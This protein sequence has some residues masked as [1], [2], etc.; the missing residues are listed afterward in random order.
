MYDSPRTKLI[1]SVFDND[2]NF[3]V[4]K[5][6]CAEYESKYN[7]AKIYDRE[8]RDHYNNL[9]KEFR[10]LFKQTTKSFDINFD[11]AT[12][13]SKVTTIFEEGI[14]AFGVA[15]SENRLSPNKVNPV[16]V[17][18]EISRT[19]V[20]KIEAVISNKSASSMS[21]DSVKDFELTDS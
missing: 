7:I 2:T 14:K 15:F 3:D 8:L 9:K 17:S 21:S 13:I 4:F 20:D 19:Y 1:K 11:D 6:V 12:L 5:A 18:R 10:N 16:I